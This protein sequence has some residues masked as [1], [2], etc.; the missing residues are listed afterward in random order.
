MPSWKWAMTW[1]AMITEI[2]I[3]ISAWRSSC[4]WFQ[5]RKTC[6]ITSPRAAM[7]AAA[8]RAGSTHSSVVTS[9]PGMV[10]PEPVIFCW[11][12]YAM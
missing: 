9:V 7:H 5:R 10:K 12:S 4:P 2:A 11:R 1:S 6:W 3:V 8:A